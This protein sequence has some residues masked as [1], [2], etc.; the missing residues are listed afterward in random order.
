[1]S[2]ETPKQTIDQ[3]TPIEKSEN[4]SSNEQTET[5]LVTLNVDV[6]TSTLKDN[7]K[8]DKENS[9]ISTNNINT[10]N[11]SDVPTSNTNITNNP[12]IPS[13]NPE[14]QKENLALRKQ[15]EMLNSIKILLEGYK[16]LKK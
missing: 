5:S 9:D 12:N 6:E 10:T 2:G 16:S 3:S 8:N 15:L 13:K 11:N 14:N 1:M 7:I 4:L